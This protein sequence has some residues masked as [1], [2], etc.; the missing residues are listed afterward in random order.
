ML[1]SII[2]WF[3][4]SLSKKLMFVPVQ[5]VSALTGTHRDCL[6]VASS[7]QE[8]ELHRLVSRDQIVSTYLV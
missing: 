3:L 7:N 6:V 4:Y 2:A 5:V 1:V 8:P